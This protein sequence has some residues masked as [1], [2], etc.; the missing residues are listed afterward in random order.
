[1]LQEL[2]G[3]WL[4]FSGVASAISSVA[5]AGPTYEAAMSKVKAVTQATDKQ[6]GQ[7]DSM[8]KKLGKTTK[9]SASEAADAMGYL[10]MAGYDTT[11]ILQAMPSVLRPC[12][13]WK[14]GP[15]TSS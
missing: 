4:L 2:L 1:M 12:R 8:A 3:D 13:S 14:P 7:L 9:F 15:W 11:Q 5:K 10:G 6:M